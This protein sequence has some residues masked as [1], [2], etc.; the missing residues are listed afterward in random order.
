MRELW[1]RVILHVPVLEYAKTKLKN[2]RSKVK[3]RS[4]PALPSA[5]LI[6]FAIRKNVLYVIMMRAVQINHNVIPESA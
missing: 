4:V 3:V 6:Y 5:C 2:A 1:V